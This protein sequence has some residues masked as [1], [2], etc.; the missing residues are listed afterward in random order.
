MPTFWDLPKDVRDIIYRQ[1]LV[2]DK[3]VT[4]EMH[5]EAIG[6]EDRFYQRDRFMPPIFHLSKK[7]ER[8]AIPFYYE[9][10][11]FDIEHM[12]LWPFNNITWP[13]HWNRVRK[14]QCTW[15]ESDCWG[16]Y[17]HVRA[18]FISLS[19]MKKLEEL[20]IQ[21]DES[22][23]VE[24]MRVTREVRQRPYIKSLTNQQNL[25]ILRF[26]GITGLL[27]LSRIKHVNFTKLIDMNGVESGGMIAGGALE[28]HVLPRLK[29]KPKLKRRR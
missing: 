12:Q 7:A 26:P 3:P 5:R 10:N 4:I 2:Y 29:P 17:G 6:C 13:R 20:N 25:A 16:R 14:V 18:V 11:V 27:T 15:D 19:K 24:Q 21:I 22:K 23:M 9:T 1:H 28:A 8:E